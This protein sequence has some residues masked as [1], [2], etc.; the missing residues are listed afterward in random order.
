MSRSITLITLAIVL[1]V[2]IVLPTSADAQYAHTVCTYCHNLNGNAGGGIPLTNF[3]LD[4]DLCLSCH[5]EG[6]P[7]TY[8]GK[9]V[10]LGATT[11]TGRKHQPG[12]VTSCVDCHDHYGETDD[13]YPPTGNGNIKLIP[14]NRVSRY[15]LPGGSTKR[16]LFRGNSGPNSQADG[17]GVFDGICEVC[18]T[19]SAFH[20]NNPGGDHN[21][22]PGADCSSCHSHTE[23]FKGNCTT[24]HS[25]GGGAPDPLTTGGSGTAGK[26]TKH[27]TGLG[28]EC[29]SCHESYYL[30]PNH[31]NGS[32]ETTGLISFIATE[33]PTANWAG[34]SGP[35]TGGCAN[36]YCHGATDGVTTVANQPS[37]YATPDA[38]ACTDCHSVGSFIDPSVTNGT[39]ATGKH[40][41]HGDTWGFACTVCH[42][43]Y[44]ANSTHVNFK[45]ETGLESVLSFDTNNPSGAWNLGT[46]SCANTYCHGATDGVTTVANEPDWYD[47]AAIACTDCHSAGSFTDPLTLN[48]TG[49]SGKHVRHVTDKGY[50]CVKCHLDY[51]TQVAY[52]VNFTFDTFL[53]NG[54]PIVNFDPVFNPSPAAYSD[55]PDTCSNSYCHGDRILGYT[56]NNN[57]TWY[58]AAGIACTNCHSNGSYIDPVRL[59]NV[60]PRDEHDKHINGENAPCTACHL[61]YN[62]TPDHVS[63]TT[64]TVNDGSANDRMN[65]N[66]PAPLYPLNAFDT[67]IGP[68]NQS[69]FGPL[70]EES[71]GPSGAG[72]CYLNCHGSWG[73]NHSPKEWW[74]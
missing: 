72:A 58:G 15:P 14:R 44:N 74:N 47:P 8:D 9:V 33:N 63:N 27:V 35:Q 6:S 38:L 16:V 37:W 42:D 46:A 73:K 13:V 24:C 48:G 71:Y 57:P 53:E 26:H 65:A 52:H 56:D 30:N 66:D 12:D 50:D 21:H 22:N 51:E 5:G 64:V 67:Y 49:N 62:E 43:G 18:H 11:H 34:D 59:G 19:Q 25:A 41:V 36:T 55:S 69:P 40:V 23:N 4:S 68:T 28:I 1:G 10:P 29:V 61:G 39:G 45:F 20:R 32:T 54:A 31:D 70:Y 17:D 60:N 3:N 7:P 2:F